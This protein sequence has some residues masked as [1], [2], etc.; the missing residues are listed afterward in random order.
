MNVLL[1]DN[2]MMRESFGTPLNGAKGLGVA[3]NTQCISKQ[4]LEGIR[5]IRSLC[6]EAEAEIKANKTMS[7][8]LCDILA[9]EIPEL[10]DSLFDVILGRGHFSVGDFN[11]ASV[12]ENPQD[13]L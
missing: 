3:E 7:A 10:S 9:E 2:R 8:R 6:D 13:T 4:L 5:H 12:A 1:K 11:D